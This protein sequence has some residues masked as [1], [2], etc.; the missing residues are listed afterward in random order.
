MESPPDADLTPSDAELLRSAADGD[1]A[2]FHQLVDRHAQRL[3]RS[4]LSL[5]PSRD[6]AEDLVQ[7]T[8]IGA[9]R[10][11]KKFDGRASVKTWLT[12]ILIRQAAKGWRRSKKHRR[13]MSIQTSKEDQ[14]INDPHLATP[15]PDEHTD[16]RLDL[17]GLIRKLAPAHREVLVLRE[18]QGLSYEEIA[19]TLGIPRGTVESRLHRARSE[20][21]QHLGSYAT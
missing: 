4:A 6:D 11:L 9:Y 13:T 2:A 12:S 14:E 17:V 8:L 10:G 5:S 20:L 19:G 3:F 15:S 21:R 16:R 7:E 18:M 1:D